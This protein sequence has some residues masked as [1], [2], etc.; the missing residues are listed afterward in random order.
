MPD[1]HYEILD[2]QLGWCARAMRAAVFGPLFGPNWRGWPA[3]RPHDKLRRLWHRALLRFMEAGWTA[4]ESDGRDGNKYHQYLRN[5]PPFGVETRARGR[6]CNKALLCPFC[7]ARAYVQEPYRHLER[8]LDA[9]VPEDT[10]LV[11]FRL[12]RQIA[13]RGGNPWTI[14]DRAEGLARVRAAIQDRYSRSRE[15]ARYRPH[16]G[17]VLLHKVEPLEDGLRFVRAGLLL[18]PRAVVGA[19]TGDLAAAFGPHDDLARFRGATFKITARGRPTR[20]AVGLALGRIAA[21]PRRMLT[22]PAADTLAVLEAFPRVRFYAAVPP[23]RR[24]L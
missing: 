21:Y 19:E 4:L 7:W 23:S 9:G 2:D 11:E 3:A 24:P 13:A 20:K 16:L 15:S 22:G 1:F 10:V 17:G 14:K 5:C 6:V 8:L 12:R 18:V